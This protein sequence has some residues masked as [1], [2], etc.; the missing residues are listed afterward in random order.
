LIK[1][2]RGI[3]QSVVILRA[4]KPDLV[5]GLG[6]YSAAPVAAAARLCRIPLVLH[7]QNIIPG[8][9]NRMLSRWAVRIYVSFED[10]ARY[11]DRRKVNWTGNPVR[12]EFLE[13][14]GGDSGT[15]R[16]SS[17]TESFTLL[18]L[19]GSQ[20]AHPINLVL[21]EAVHRVQQ[22]DRLH[23]VH[24]TGADDEQVVAEA[25]RRSGIAH[26][27]KAFFD[28]MHLKYRAADLI[29]CRAGATTVAEITASGKAAIFIPFP[30]AADNHQELNARSLV[31][32]GA[33]EIIH[34]RDLSPGALGSRIHF[35]MNHR[36]ALKTMADRAAA[37]GRPEAARAIVHDCYRLVE[38]RIDLEGL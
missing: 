1:L 24:Q 8:I 9:T 15:V 23:V 26:T 13:A 4:L 30:H 5:L 16:V 36:Q 10:S 3:W 19:G 25:Y 31:D 18:V 35:F 32:G 11:F 6:S 34:E 20:G 27:V 21:P 12:R 7:E 2:P 29:I 22:R 33:A 28:D 38:S 37:F 14:T 17:N